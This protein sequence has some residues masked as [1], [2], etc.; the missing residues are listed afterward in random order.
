MLR[1]EA[2]QLHGRTPFGALEAIAAWLSSIG[3]LRSDHRS[4]VCLGDIEYYVKAEVQPDSCWDPRSRLINN[5]K[6]ASG[7][8]LN[9][10]T[11]NL[12]CL[13]AL[14]PPKQMNVT[15][16]HGKLTRSGFASVTPMHAE[17]A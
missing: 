3:S 6:V 12:S 10:H 17:S 13:Q 1:D 9:V 7:Q 2:S 5:Y 4:S 8:A 14:E 15:T 16:T 11:Y